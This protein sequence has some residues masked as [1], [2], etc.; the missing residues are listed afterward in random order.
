MKRKMME[1]EACKSIRHVSMISCACTCIRSECECMWTGLLKHEQFP[2]GS[3]RGYTE[4]TRF[5]VGS[6]RGVQR[7]LTSTVRACAVFVFICVRTAEAHGFPVEA[8]RS[9]GEFLGLS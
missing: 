4:P 8:D 9:H 5:P 7:A 6:A 3:V 2:V 1:E